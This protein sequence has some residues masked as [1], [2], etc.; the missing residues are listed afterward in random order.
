[1]II[2][3]RRHDIGFS[4]AHSFSMT[5]PGAFC[6]LAIKAVPNAPRNEVAGWLGDAL[7]VRVRAPALNGR[8]NEE[9]RDFLAGA[10]NLP[11]HAVTIT[12]GAKSRQKLINV[13]GLTLAEVIS[14]LGAGG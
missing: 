6:T 11:R 12:R 7:K 8:A 10:L 1:M 5:A 9:L 2:I 4:I 13:D 3:G 14:R